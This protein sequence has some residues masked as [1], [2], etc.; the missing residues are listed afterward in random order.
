[1]PL[2]AVSVL[3]IS[4]SNISISENSKSHNIYGRP[5]ELNFGQ[6]QQYLRSNMSMYRAPSTPYQAQNCNIDYA[7]YRGG[8]CFWGYDFTPDQG[9]DQ[10]P[11]HP[12]SQAT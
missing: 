2:M 7:D 10:G 1:M 3:N 12:I 8:F 11:L 6:Q 5:F 4:F 9:A